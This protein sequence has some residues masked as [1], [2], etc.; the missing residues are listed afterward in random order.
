[1]NYVARISSDQAK[2]A[3]ILLGLGKLHVC[4]ELELTPLMLDRVEIPGAK[5][6]PPRATVFARLR[7]YYEAAGVEF[8]NGGLPGVRPKPRAR[9]AAEP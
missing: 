4:R 9:V 6:G 8:T 7:R 5:G 1:M 3:R 2:A